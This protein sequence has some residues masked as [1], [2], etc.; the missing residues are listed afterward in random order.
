MQFG[1]RLRLRSLP[2]VRRWSKA[3]HH[4]GG[5]PASVRRRRNAQGRRRT[6]QKF[7]NGSKP[8]KFPPPDQQPMCFSWM[9][10]R[11]STAAT[12]GTACTWDSAGNTCHMSFFAATSRENWLVVFSAPERRYAVQP[13]PASVCTSFASV[14]SWMVGFSGT[15]DQG[16]SHP[17]STV[18]RCGLR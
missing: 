6:C 4:N 18:C 16:R 8:H 17:L 11:F 10:G 14:G 9:S 15:N 5:R 13:K 2:T 12:S 7:E 3:S 1:L